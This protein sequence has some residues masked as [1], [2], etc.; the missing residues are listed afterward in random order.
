MKD[1]YNASSWLVDRNISLGNGDRNAVVTADDTVSYAGLLKSI[2]RVQNALKELDVRREERVALI[3]NDEPAFPAWFLGCMRSGVVPIPLSTML[4]GKDLG[5]IIS[6]AIAQVVVLSGRYAP[7][8][9]AICKAAPHL[10]AAIIIGNEKSDVAV[11]V[12]NWH[13]FQNVTEAPVADTNVDSPAFWLYSSGTTGFPKGT[14]H[15]HFNLE[16]TATTYAKTVLEVNQNDVFF[17]AAKLFFAFGLGNSLTFPFSVGASVILDPAWAT[18]RGVAETVS[19]FKPTLFFGS[20]GLLASI[21]DSG[22][23]ANSFESVRLAVTAGEALPSEINKKFSAA[24]GFP[25]LDGIGSTEAL[26]IFLSNRPNDVRFGTTGRPV[27]GYKLMLLD[28]ENKEILE[29]DVPGYLH[30]SGE[31]TAIGYWCRTDANKNAFRGEWLRTGDVYVRSADGFYQFL[32]RNNDMIKL[33]GIWVSPAEVESVLVEHEDV[34]EA[35]VVGGYNDD[36]LETSVAFI[37]PKSGKIIDEAAI[38]EHC[39]SRMASFKR[40][41]TIVFVTELPKTAT[42]KIQRYQLREQIAKKVVDE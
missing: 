41:R 1:L 33:G 25:V 40:P 42:G 38:A 8:L 19:K 24:F 15:R 32:G 35:A 5:D 6:D 30:V 4:T 21:M 28:D 34:L 39:R 23:P 29:P 16:A 10:K 9:P 14:I 11:K 12:F 20:P 2:Y 26:H 7:I 36:G 31:S 17:S 13:E 27:E 18:P 3:L 22:V 37:V